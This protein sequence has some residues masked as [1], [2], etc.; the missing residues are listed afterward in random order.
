VILSPFEIDHYKLNTFLIGV[1]S[2]TTG[3]MVT[4]LT[5]IILCHEYIFYLIF[6][7]LNFVKKK[8]EDMFFSKKIIHKFLQH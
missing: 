3:K 6:K 8:S 7:Y 4:I 5:K 1:I 2:L